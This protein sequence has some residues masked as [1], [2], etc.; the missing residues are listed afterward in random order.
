MEGWKRQIENLHKTARLPVARGSE[1]YYN[2]LFKKNNL[3]KNLDI[4]KKKKW[5]YS[6]IKKL[7][8]GENRSLNFVTI[9]RSDNKRLPSVFL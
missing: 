5:N 8:Q 3:K 6:S 7:S 9:K 4:Y 1:K 2:F